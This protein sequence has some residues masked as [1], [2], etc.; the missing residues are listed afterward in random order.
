MLERRSKSPRTVDTIQGVGRAARPTTFVA[1]NELVAQIGAADLAAVGTASVTVH[2]PNS[3]V[4]TTTSQ[5]LTIS[6]ASI[7]AVAFQMNPA[8]TGDVKFASVSF[9]TNALWSV[10][11][12]GTPSYALVVQGEIFLTVSV[13]SGSAQLVAL[14]QAPLGSHVSATNNAEVRRFLRSLAIYIGHVR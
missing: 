7:D 14:N 12:G 11:V 4:G 3:S 10:D 5:T 6:A 8:H 9:P 1:G 13:G 2:D